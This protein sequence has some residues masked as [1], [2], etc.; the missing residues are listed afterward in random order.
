[1]KMTLP[2]KLSAI[3]SILVLV[4][5]LE[6][7]GLVKIVT[8]PATSESKFIKQNS[9]NEKVIVFV[10]GVGGSSETTWKNDE[11]KA[12]FPDLVAKNNDLIGFDV[13]VASYYKSGSG[14]NSNIY[15]LA[16]N[17]NDILENNRIFPK[18][19][20]EDSSVAY[21]KVYFVTHSM[22]N[23]VTRT[24][25]IQTKEFDPKQLEIPLI[26]S[27][28]SPSEGSQIADIGNDVNKEPQLADMEQLERNSFLSLLNLIWKAKPRDTEIGCAYEKKPLKGIFLVVTEE[29]AT[30]VCSRK[31]DGTKNDGQEYMGLDEDHMSIVKPANANSKSFLWLKEQLTKESAKK[32]WEVDRWKQKQII[33]AGKDYPESNIH[34]AMMALVI[35][36]HLPDVKIERKYTHGDGAHVYNELKTEKIDIYAE[37]S[38]SLLF[39]YL[40]IDP[41]EFSNRWG[42]NKAAIEKQHHIEEL[43]K[44][45]VGAGLKMVFYPQFGFDSP[46]QLVMLKSKAEQLHLM[47]NGRVNL[48]ELSRF[49]KQC[50]IGG[51]T[52]FFYRN[53]GYPGLK[54]FYKKEGLEFGNIHYYKHVESYQALEDWD[55]QH[56]S[57]CLV[58]VGYAT[59]PELFDKRLADRYV[60]IDDD[61]GFFPIHYPGA[62]AH[63]FLE[64]EFPEINKALA[65][66]DGIITTKEMADLNR[67]GNL[68]WKNKSECE[69]NNAIEE[70]AR[71]FLINKKKLG[72]GSVKHSSTC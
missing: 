34:L 62:L 21:K 48:S 46:F 5:N 64:K 68:I 65:K 72:K 31:E 43:N 13:F 19:N 3:F 10:H 1:M 4:L 15:E 8:N 53:D 11:T 37:Y 26:V 33:V 18:T 61:K 41:I 49:S 29:S 42:N 16:R 66:L 20:G 52:G 56:Q 71:D 27:F 24:A 57:Q 58:V 51:E 70:L 2:T 6:G 32:G 40:G 38:G 67:A 59:D 7:C 54:Q 69:R 23:L 36:D 17:L 28:A 45:I 60:Q 50:D 9:K 30:A 12:Y 35:E 44:R 14:H 55:R 22:G 25:L 47:H 39:A 63:S